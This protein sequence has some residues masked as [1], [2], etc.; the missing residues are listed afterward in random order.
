M[1]S[2]LGY[3]KGTNDTNEI[4]GGLD[5]F[6]CSPNAHAR[7]ERAAWSVLVLAE[8]REGPAWLVPVLAERAHGINRISR[9]A[10]L[11]QARTLGL[12]QAALGK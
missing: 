10:V 1:E 7:R 3:A 5:C 12:I 2:A 6:L 8:G 11:V 9:K 4:V